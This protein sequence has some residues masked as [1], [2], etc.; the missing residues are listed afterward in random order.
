[1]KSSEKDKRKN[2]GWGRRL[3]RAPVSTRSTGLPFG[4][5]GLIALRHETAHVTRELFARLFLRPFGLSGFHSGREQ[6]TPTVARERHIRCV[7]SFA[8]PQLTGH[9]LV[10]GIERLAVVR[11]LAATDARTLTCAHL[12]PPVGIRETLPRGGD[13]VGFASH[14]DA[15]DLFE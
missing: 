9:L 11:E 4:R 5:T 3:T 14:E 2:P 13:D 6:S 8:V 12:Q 7:E 1:K 10:L 15:L